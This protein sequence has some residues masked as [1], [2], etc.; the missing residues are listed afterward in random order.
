MPCKGPALG[1]AAGSMTGVM[2]EQDKTRIKNGSLSVLVHPA[3][4]PDRLLLSDTEKGIVL[5]FFSKNKSSFLVCS[6]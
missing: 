1:Q 3:Y 6:Y 4:S 5:R 2:E